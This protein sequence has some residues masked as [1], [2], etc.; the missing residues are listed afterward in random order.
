MLN[1]CQQHVLDK[2]D[3]TEAVDYVMIQFK[4]ADLK[5]FFHRKEGLELQHLFSTICKVQQFSIRI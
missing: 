2:M 4:G 5:G 3:Q 1:L